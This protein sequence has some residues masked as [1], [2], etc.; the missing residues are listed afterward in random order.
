V[1]DTRRTR[2][3][4]GI[5]E[6]GPGSTPLTAAARL[7]RCDTGP[8]QQVSEVVP[9]VT[10]PER[11]SRASRTTRLA[12]RAGPRAL[13]VGWAAG[14][15]WQ[16]TEPLISSMW[17]FGQV[18]DQIEFDRAQRVGVGLDVLVPGSI[19]DGGAVGRR[20]IACPFLESG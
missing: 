17:W 16:Q 18:G 9:L 5:T 12:G 8:A 1:G 20:S 11:G 14:R 6:G 2:M 7:R 19:R 15:S 10:E 3:H 13:V 4:H